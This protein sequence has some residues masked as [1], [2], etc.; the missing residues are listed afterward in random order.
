MSEIIRK[1]GLSRFAR[2]LLAAHPALAAELADPAPF[3]RA[4]MMNALEAPGDDR[5]KLRELRNRV[6]LRVMARDLSGRADL[7]EVCGTMSDLAEVSIQFA[8]KAIGGENLIARNI[9]HEVRRASDAGV[10]DERIEVLR[11]Q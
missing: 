10:D 5:R 7:A 2:R 6:V 1:L 8:L 3:T 11:H 9:G 4:E